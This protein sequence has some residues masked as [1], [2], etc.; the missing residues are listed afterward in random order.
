MFNLADRT[1]NSTAEVILTTEQTQETH[2]LRIPQHEAQIALMTAWRL[3]P[4][5]VS[6][7]GLDDE[8]G[9]YLC[10]A[11]A[12]TGTPLLVALIGE[13]SVETRA[14]TYAE[15]KCARLAT[16]PSHV[17]SWQSRDELFQRYGGAIRA[18]E[19]LISFSG[20]PEHLDEM[21]AVSVAIELQKISTVEA[22]EILKTSDNPHT[23]LL[24]MAGRLRAIN[25]RE[26]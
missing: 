7:C 11:D 24:T 26:Q 9:G 4:E 8:K 23:K 19:I 17:S 12:K 1:P 5:L 15:E 2:V 6:A 3:L 21:L 16:C 25:E 10:V 13:K 22:V 20:L 18:G 14:R